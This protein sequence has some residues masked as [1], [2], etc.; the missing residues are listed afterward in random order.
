MLCGRLQ[1][2][3]QDVQAVV[4]LLTKVVE[5][6]PDAEIWVAAY[7][8]ITQ[9]AQQPTPP[10][11]ITPPTASELS[12][13]LAE[14]R[15]LT[16]PNK[17]IASENTPQ[18]SYRLW[19]TEP[20]AH[21]EKELQME[22]GT[23]LYIGVPGFEDAFFGGVTNLQS[24]AKTVFEKCQEGDDPL[25]NKKKSGWQGWPSS[26]NETK[27]LDWFQRIMR[28]FLGLA[29]KDYSIPTPQMKILRQV[30]T[31]LPESASLHKLDIGFVRNPRI[32]GPV[33]IPG[34]L[35]SNPNEDTHESTWLDLARY[36]RA[37]FNIQ[38]SRRFVQG[39]T[40]CG[41]LMRLWE[42]DR[43]GGIASSAFDINEDGLRFVSTV[44]GYLWMTD[45]QLG[46][47]P[48]IT[49][50]GAQRYITITKGDTTERLVIVNVIKQYSAIDGRGTVCWKVHPVGDRSKQ[51]VVKDSWQYPDRDEEG[52]YLLEA[53]KSGVDHVARYYHHETVRVGGKDDTIV[54]NVRKGLDIGEAENA[55][56]VR[57]KKEEERKRQ[58][59]LFRRMARL[60]IQKKAQT[61]R[62]PPVA[63]TSAAPKEN[64]EEPSMRDRVH[65]RV[66]LQDCGQ[67]LYNATSRVALLAALEGA[68]TGMWRSQ[69]LV[70]LETDC[71][72]TSIAPS[73]SR[74]PP[75]RHINQQCV[76]E[77]RQLGLA[78]IF[79]RPRPRDQGKSPQNTW[80]SRQNRNQSF[81]GHWSALW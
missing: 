8:L 66:V 9:P 71:V 48:T 2:N 33:L 39:F 6:A 73:K 62:M 23:S 29:A 1:S 81:H 10:E 72:R 50:W 20:G 13:E 45:E 68:I 32:C 17:P 30:N 65:R 58:E 55:Y 36:V 79:D 53:T 38:E 34:E 74:Y 42:F 14:L 77:R 75:P 63:S 40:L 52:E 47:D 69:L 43:L 57:V 26:A 64:E 59:D 24:I 67:P 54:D 15:A 12:V 44:L 61:S 35:K 70:M 3:Q 22:L 49:L 19:S 7:E 31:P 4:P 18:P 51:F 56:K 25:F 28:I 46:F 76:G 11:E 21:F 5:K 41:P 78:W 60:G 37:V 16:T 27:V 80:C